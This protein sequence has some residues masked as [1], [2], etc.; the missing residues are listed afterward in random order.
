M[1]PTD[2]KLDA[3]LAEVGWLRRF[4][5][6]LTKDPGAAGDLA[7]DTLVAALGE[8][9]G[10]RRPRAWLAAVAKRLAA[11]GRRRDRVRDDAAALSRSGSAT[12]GPGA[13]EMAERLELQRMVG[14]AML[15]LDEPYRGTLYAIYFQGASPEDIARQAGVTAGTVRWRAFRAR[16]QIRE[17]LVQRS[18][19]TWDQLS[20]QLLPI[21]GAFRSAADSAA[22]HWGLPMT[23]QS[24]ATGAAAGALLALVSHVALPEGVDAL[25][26]A[27]NLPSGDQN[28]AV[29]PVPG[30]PELTEA[31]P[32]AAART[33]VPSPT[34]PA[35]IRI[36]RGWLRTEDGEVPGGSLRFTRGDDERRVSTEQSAWGIEG[37]TPGTWDVEVA[38]EGFAPL[39]TALDV[40]PAGL[41]DQDFVLVETGMFAVRVL[42]ADGDS[43]PETL[44]SPIPVRR[45]LSV[46]VTNDKGEAAGTWRGRTFRDSLSQIPADALGL[47]VLSTPPPVSLELRYGDAVVDRIRVS[48]VEEVIPWRVNVSLLE[49]AERN[50]NFLTFGSENASSGQLRSLADQMWMPSQ[51]ELPAAAAAGHLRLPPGAYKLTLHGPGRGSLDRTFDVGAEAVDLGEL[52]VP[53]KGANR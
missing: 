7:Q 34:L 19:R 10:L 1:S 9:G 25:P 45:M 22:L 38:S 40:P 5:L 44:G 11:A 3:L 4:A 51:L 37:L 30:E 48:R 52:R 8:G 20:L 28:A 13:D 53:A 31:L 32:A 17:V 46:H 23:I 2:Q 16:E 49:Q 6:H 47:V 15:E 27:A 24:A 12:I 41:L 39:Y 35:G 43:L 33:Q 21:G 18:A 14:E 29:I 50:V 26:S 36:A 42:N